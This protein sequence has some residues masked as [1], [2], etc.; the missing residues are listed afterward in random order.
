MAIINVI[1]L[2]EEWLPNSEL[3]FVHQNNDTVFN[4]PIIK[5]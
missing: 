3:R 5:T 1:M 4:S 2:F